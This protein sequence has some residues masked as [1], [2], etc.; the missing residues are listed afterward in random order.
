MATP[1]TLLKTDPTYGSDQHGLVW[2][3]RFSPNPPA[4]SISSDTASEFFAAPD[5]KSG[6]EFLWLH[7]SLSNSASES[8][9][10]H[11]LTLPDAFHE[12][13]HSEVGS[14]RLE[15]DGESLVAVIHDV[16]FDFA[17]DASAVATASLCIEPRLLV[18]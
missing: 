8:W 4:Q 17:F 13:L 12:S 18:T 1:T 9:L 11:S 2:G 5:A 3:Y 15:I 6:D 10:R 14:T 7:F 16:L